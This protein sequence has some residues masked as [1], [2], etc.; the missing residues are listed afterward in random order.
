MSTVTESPSSGDTGDTGDYKVGYGKPPLHSRFAKGRSGNPK[1]RPKGTRNL[2]TD[3]LDELGERIQVREGARTRTVS[4]QRAFVMSLMS[5]TLKGDARA[6]S[7]L[8]SMMMRLL[9]TG[10]VADDLTTPLEEEELE[11]IRTF[12]ER[13]RRGE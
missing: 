5:R 3:L 8:V 4:K 13:L 7:L 6:G 2:K 9:D 11:I 1:G 12:E 10:E